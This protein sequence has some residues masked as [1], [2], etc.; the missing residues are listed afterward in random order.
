MT[1]RDQCPHRHVRCLTFL[2]SKD[3][4]LS[5]MRVMVLHEQSPCDNLLKC[6][7]PWAATASWPQSGCDHCIVGRLSFLF[8][9]SFY[10]ALVFINEGDCEL[11][12]PRWECHT[13]NL[14][15]KDRNLLAKSLFLKVGQ[16]TCVL[17]NMDLL[18]PWQHRSC[19]I[20][21]ECNGQMVKWLKNCLSDLNDFES[22]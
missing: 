10:P 12:F 5:V 2:L 21:T 3:N 22:E 7:I 6:S 14:I 20:A 1:R 8:V 9:T 4:V 16:K 11:G 18:V 19:S 13:S 15:S 17:L